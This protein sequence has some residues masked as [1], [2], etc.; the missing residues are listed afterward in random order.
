[1]HIELVHGYKLLESARGLGGF[2]IGF[3]RKTKSLRDEY[4]TN[5]KL[6]GVIYA[7][8]L[9]KDVS[10]FAQRLEETTFGLGSN[11]YLK[12]TSEYT[13]SSRRAAKVDW[14]LFMKVISTF[15]SSVV[16]TYEMDDQVLAKIRTVII[17]IQ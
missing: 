7:N 1:M 4:I 13:L 11:L 15:L 17:L 16:Q 9:I 6:I 2:T 3:A 14:T 10:G 12:R 8:N 5:E